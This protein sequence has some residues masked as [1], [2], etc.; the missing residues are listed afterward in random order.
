M[1]RFDAFTVAISSLKLK[2]NYTM[3]TCENSEKSWEF[4]A[5]KD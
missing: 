2:L 5:F 1:Y 3:K 4:W